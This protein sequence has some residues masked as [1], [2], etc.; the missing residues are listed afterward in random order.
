VSSLV[1]EANPRVVVVL[2]VVRVEGPSDRGDVLFGDSQGRLAV[3][4]EVETPYPGPLRLLL[5]G[6]GELACPPGLALLV[7]EEVDSAPGGRRRRGAAL[8]GLGLGLGLVGE[9]LH[10]GADVGQVSKEYLAHGRG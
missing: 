1:G 4:G 6:G 10:E 2:R 7:R 3:A 8:L 5:D 9:G